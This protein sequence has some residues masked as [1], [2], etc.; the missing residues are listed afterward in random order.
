MAATRLAITRV[1]T[2]ERLAD[3]MQRNT[4]RTSGALNGMPFGN[5]GNWV[6][7]VTITTANTPVAHGLGRKPVG[8]LFT[9]I[10]LNAVA[11][12]ESLPANQPPDQTKMFSFVATGTVKVDI[13]FF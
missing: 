10:Q 12:C 3:D 1:H 6:K 9:R 5:G 7:N 4:Q 8:Y 13:F 11:V 2:G